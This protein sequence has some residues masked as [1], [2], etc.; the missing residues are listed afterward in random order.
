MGI[1]TRIQAASAIAYH[2]DIL[3][4]AVLDAMNGP[5]PAVTPSPDQRNASTASDSISSSQRTP[6]EVARALEMRRNLWS[7]SKE[8]ST[9]IVEE[10]FTPQICDLLSSCGGIVD[11]R[12]EPIFVIGALNYVRE[13]W[14]SNSPH[15]LMLGSAVLCVRRL[16]QSRWDKET[17]VQ[18]ALCPEREPEAIERVLK[19]VGR[20]HGPDGQERWEW[21]MQK[22]PLRLPIKEV[23]S[24]WV[25]R[26]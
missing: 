1:M 18:C 26:S 19:H 13:M 23:R 16:L 21:Y 20:E 10:V 5:L 11:R 25:E 22:W 2:R 6:E 9:H 17:L 14:P 4:Q 7:L 15:I 3:M 24:V 8:Y 12:N